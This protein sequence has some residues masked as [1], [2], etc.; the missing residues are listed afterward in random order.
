MTF[1]KQTGTKRL[2]RRKDRHFNSEME[3]HHG[4]FNDCTVFELWQKKIQEKKK[5][6]LSVTRHA[7]H[8]AV[9]FFM[10]EVNGH[11]FFYGRSL[12]NS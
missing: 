11:R 3:G 5:P 6:L 4:T 1:T 2:P 7:T 8:A 12:R 10:A 9:F